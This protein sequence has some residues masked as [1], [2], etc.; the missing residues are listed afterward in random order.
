M[1][2]NLTN[3]CC[4]ATGWRPYSQDM[5]IIPT[6]LLLAGV[7]VVVVGLIVVLVWTLR[8]SGPG[9]RGEVIRYAVII[10]LTAL[11]ALLMADAG[12]WR[13]TWWATLLAV[14]VTIAALVAMRWRH[15]HP[16]LLAILTTLAAALFPAVS[17]VAGWAYLSLATHR[18]W[19]A[20][21]G[22]GGLSL[23]LGVGVAMEQGSVVVE[24]SG[25]TVA[26]ARWLELATLTLFN[27]IFLVA[28]A[29]IGSYLGARRQE[30]ENLVER[31][32]AAEREQALARE[33]VRAEERNRIAREM[34]DVLA[35][36]I[37]LISMHAGAL[38]Y[39]DDLSREEARVAAQ[40]IQASSHEALNELRLI[41]GQ[42][43][44]M[45]TDAPSKPQP[46]LASLRDLLEEHRQAG[47]HVEVEALLDADP[48][49]A[50]SRHAY[51]VVQESLTNAAKHAPG[52]T[53]RLTV[54]GAPE[55]GLT[56]RVSNPP[57]VA[58]ATTPG[59][60]LGLVG[61]EER[62]QLV[63]GRMETGP[64]AAGDF[65][66]DVWLPWDVARPS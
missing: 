57:S 25:G 54:L 56:I 66:V 63:G 35:H 34:H 36:K 12:G 62:V 39:R 19:R 27:A 3:G 60:G 28:L 37:S 44:Q 45:D 23:V 11:G 58:S 20:T 41:L 9:R 52:A 29:A 10:V 26:V 49:A 65:T 8:R 30:R 24:G 31:V 5:S 18:K 22:V 15:R 1:A 14:V 13:G 7:L 43:R 6:L 4:A 51:R 32:A 33:A 61:L 16:V 21:L 40:T 38:A 53:V 48:P 46:T 17:A 59:A 47:H 55:R 64:G 42:L 2:R 50:V